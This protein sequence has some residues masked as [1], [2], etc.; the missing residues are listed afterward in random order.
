M[1]QSG[2]PGALA[3]FA[4]LAGAALPAEA[5]QA[6]VQGPQQTQEEQA[7]QRQA[8]QAR[9]AAERYLQREEAADTGR[10]S[11]KT[12]RANQDASVHDEASGA[13]EG[14]RPARTTN[15]DA[16]AANGKGR[17][18]PPSYGP[19][20]NPRQP[21]AVDPARKD[22]AEVHDETDSLARDPAQGRAA[23]PQK[24][25]QTRRQAWQPEGPPAP[26]PL[27]AGDA[28]TTGVVPASVPV[29]IPAPAPAP[30]PVVPSSRALNSCVGSACTDAAGGSYNLGPTGTGVSSG[31]RL[32]S[33]SGPTVQCF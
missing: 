8:Q 29:P 16:D 33:R 9:Q 23:P 17:P 32:C 5:R 13:S 12:E 10:Q 15:P 2:L 14:A 25:K 27:R 6:R 20:L 4:L 11:Q 21:Q 26:R 7:Q 28:R 22:P 24:E 18:A 1:R 3:L 19:V 30:Q 31:G